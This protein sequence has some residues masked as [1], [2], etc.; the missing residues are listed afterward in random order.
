MEGRYPKGILLILT[1]CGDRAEEAGLN[2]W[3]K[4]VFLPRVTASGTLRHP[5]RYRN[6]AE[7]LGADK[8]RY[9]DILETDSGDLGACMAEFDGDIETAGRLSADASRDGDATHRRVQGY[10]TRVQAPVENR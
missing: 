9:M 6:T 8:S 3:Y 1:D 4:E 2:S 7:V 5:N 10:G